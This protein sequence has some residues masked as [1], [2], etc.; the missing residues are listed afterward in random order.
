MGLVC[1]VVVG[2]VADLLFARG[3][4]MLGPVVFAAMGPAVIPELLRH[5][6]DDFDLTLTYRALASGQVDLIAGD[7][8]AGL[9]EA[10]PGQPPTKTTLALGTLRMLTSLIFRPSCAGAC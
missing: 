6:S 8:T 4:W 3:K 9:E 2:I 10:P 5:A 7:A 1:G